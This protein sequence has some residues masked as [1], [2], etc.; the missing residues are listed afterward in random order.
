MTYITQQCCGKKINDILYV[1]LFVT[2]AEV[3]PR[4]PAIGDGPQTIGRHI[5]IN[6]EI[7]LPTQHRLIL[8]S[9]RNI[10]FMDVGSV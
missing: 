7:G 1:L 3:L 8:V 9:P 5:K 4:Q 2:S 10:F 6:R